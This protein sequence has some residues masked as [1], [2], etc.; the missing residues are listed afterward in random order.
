MKEVKVCQCEICGTQ[1]ND[2]RTAEWCERSHNDKHLLEM[3][4]LYLLLAQ[5][6]GIKFQE[7]QHEL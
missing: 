7:T 1:Y 3:T 2:R 6:L 4:Y 5:Q